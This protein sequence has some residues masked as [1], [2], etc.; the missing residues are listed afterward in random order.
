MSRRTA[1][2]LAVSTLAASFSSALVHAAP[3]P[4]KDNTL[5]Q[6]GSA[7]QNAAGVKYYLVTR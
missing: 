6:T 7:V 3:P 5:V 1:L 4:A 2:A